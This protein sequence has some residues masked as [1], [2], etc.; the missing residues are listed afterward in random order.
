MRRTAIPPRPSC[1]WAC[2]S[3]GW[4]VALPV[5]FVI[6]RIILKGKPQPFLMEVPRYRVPRLRD[7]VGRMWENGSEFLMRAGTVI[8]AMSIVIWAMLYFPRPAEVEQ[9]VT[10]QYISQLAETQGVSDAQAEALVTAEDS[11]HAEALGNLI[12]GAYIEQSVM[13]RMGQAVQPIFAP[14]GFDW[15][16]TVG[17]LASFP[18]RE[19]I[20]ATMGIIYN[21]GGDVDE[22]SDDLKSAMAAAQWESGARAGQPVFTVAVALAIMVFFALCSQ[23]GATVATVAKESSWGW[24]LFSFGYMTALAWIGAVVVYQVAAAVS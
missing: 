5:A 2:T 19:V 8:F 18:A 7:V 9:Q 20:I 21:L 10:A 23:C 3:W 22:D 16:I 6:N 12:E 4:W 13:G 24:A 14:A 11:E 15:K 1:C 17:V